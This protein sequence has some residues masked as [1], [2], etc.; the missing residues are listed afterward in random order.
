MVARHLMY[1]CLLLI[2]LVSLLLPSTLRAADTGPYRVLASIR[3][4]ALL[5]QELVGD[6]PVQVDTL[7]PAGATTHDFVLSPSD[8]VHIRQADSVLW[9]GPASEPYLR[10]VVQAHPAA[11][12]WEE[13]PGLLKLPARDALHSHGGSGHDSPDHH[14]HD[15]SGIDPHIWWSVPNAIQLAR[16]LEQQIARAR[17]AWAATL[18]QNRSALEAALQTQLLDQRAR[19]A[20]GFK[21]FLLAH[22]AFHYLEEDLGIQSDAAIL[23]DPEA[24]PGV[25]H[26]L[27]LKQRVQAQNIGCVLT[28]VLVPANLIDKID[29]QPPLLRQPMDELGWDYPGTRYSEWLQQAYQKVAECVGLSLN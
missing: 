10:K 26:L 29:T 13:L 17:P 2:L 23:L 21:P 25:K 5:A 22:D 24:K 3:P 27:A 9:L 7:L 6:L 12:A 4:A 19:F 11:L 20:S 1:G 8:L 28:G 16:T 15:A 18:Q 14:P